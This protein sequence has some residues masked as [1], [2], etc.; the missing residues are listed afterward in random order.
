MK[1][2]FHVLLYQPLYNL[3]IAL[4]AIMPGQ[5]FGLA[6]LA[7]TIIIRIILHPFSAAALRSQ[8]LMQHMQPQIS[9][10]KA[11][12]KDD[13]TG[14][15]QASMELYKTN[16]VNPFSSCLPLLLQLPVLLALYWVLTAGLEAIDPSILYSFTPRP[17]A[18]SPVA[19]GFIKL[20]ENSYVIAVLAGAAQ[21]VQTK[22]LQV[23]KPEVHTKGSKD[24]EMMSAMNKQML[25][26]MPIMTVVIGVSLPAG[27]TLYWL[28]ST[29]LTAA[30]QWYIFRSLDKEKAS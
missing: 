25:Y 12:F 4:V 19:F 22:M 18:V 11:K 14:F 3:M 9:E 2:F 20:F 28:F 27:L 7:I 5:D 24:E 13:K 16:K 30:Q 10:L 26:L 15:N 29:L 17:D 6:I 21:Y 23:P 8:R 1:Q